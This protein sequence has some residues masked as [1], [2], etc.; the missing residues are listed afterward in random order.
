MSPSMYATAGST[1]GR[2]VDARLPSD[3]T[4]ADGEGV[5]GTGFVAGL[6]MP[7]ELA[8]A[9]PSTSTVVARSCTRGS[10]VQRPRGAGLRIRWTPQAETR[11]SHA[12]LPTLQCHRPIGPHP[13]TMH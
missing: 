8:Q 2:A 3:G 7:L 9:A 6:V 10:A 11:R 4:G 1:A 13:P 12:S 5:A